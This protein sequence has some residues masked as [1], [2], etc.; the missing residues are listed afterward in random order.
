MICEGDELCP[1]CGGSLSTYD[2]VTRIIKRAKGLKESIL[3]RRR[4][5][6]SCGK[7]HRELPDSLLR[8][9]QYE[10][11]II[12]NVVSG[13]ITPYDLDYED[14]PCEMTMKRWIKYY[15]ND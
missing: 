1:I 3:I 5:C 4:Q 10:K 15:K 14:Y 6:K 9:K 2:H 13:D 11:E 12:E 8:Y 7:L